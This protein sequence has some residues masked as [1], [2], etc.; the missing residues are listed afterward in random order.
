MISFIGKILKRTFTSPLEKADLVAGILGAIGG[1][2]TFWKPDLGSLMGLLS[3]AAFFGI[4]FGV[5]VYRLIFSPYWI[6]RDEA[7]ARLDVEKSLDAYKMSLPRLLV[8][9]IREA[10]MHVKSQIQEGRR[11]IFR[12][13]QVWFRN[14]FFRIV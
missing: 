10:P 4:L 14:P 6:Y 9:Q 1:I 2:I 7:I 11:R 3:G 5:L 12:V 8:D 13:I